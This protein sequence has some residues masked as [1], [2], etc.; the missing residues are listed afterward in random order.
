MAPPAF[1]HKPTL[2]GE[3]VVLRP[4][5]DGDLDALAAALTD[6]DVLR[7]TGS[8]HSCSA[9]LPTVDERVRE[10]YGTR[11]SQDQR[12]D[13][14]IVDRAGGRCGGEVVLNEWEPGNE[15]CNFRILV[16]PDGQDRGLGSEA[17]MLLLDYAFEHLPLH[18]IG[19]EVYEFNPRALR[20][21][22]KVGFVVEGR[23]RDAL[24]FDGQRVDAVLMSLLRTDPRPSRLEA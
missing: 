5:A 22:E 8:V 2:V 4:Y 18:R 11:S 19:L 15:S 14:M 16:G 21:Y 9:P 20:V 7:L 17:T 12:L 13:L 23:R 3:H 10:W 24:V 6:P 1:A